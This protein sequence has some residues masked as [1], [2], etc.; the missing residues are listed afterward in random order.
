MDLNINLKSHG[1][2]HRTKHLA[3]Y[4]HQQNAAHIRFAPI[5]SKTFVVETVETRSKFHNHAFSETSLRV[6]SAQ[7]LGLPN[8]I[9]PL[10]KHQ[11]TA[12]TAARSVQFSLLT[13]AV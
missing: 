9:T 13:L 11:P 7:I 3:T 1:S 4:R 12:D 2:I 8:E 5:G 6:C 10:P